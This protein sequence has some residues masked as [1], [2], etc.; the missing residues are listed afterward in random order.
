MSNLSNILK[1]VVYVYEKNSN[2]ISFKEIEK[3][4][5]MNKSSISVW[6]K[7]LVEIWTIT[8]VNWTKWIFLKKPKLYYS[9]RNLLEV[10]ELIFEDSILTWSASLELQWVKKE[11]YN[12]EIDFKTFYWRNR[13]IEDLNISYDISFFKEKVRYMKEF[14]KEIISENWILYYSIEKSLLDKI[15]IDLKKWNKY[16]DFSEIKFWEYQFDIEKL[17][18]LSKCYNDKVKNELDRFIKIIEEENY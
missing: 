10:W 3:E 5:N 6:L 14:E 17:K 9:K 1:V 18:D 11:K 16:L 15:E 7:K 4:T 12:Q 2:F 13:K 8:Q